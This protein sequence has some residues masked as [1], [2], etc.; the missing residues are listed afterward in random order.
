LTLSQGHTI[1]PFIIVF[2]KTKEWT[3]C[4]SQILVKLGGGILNA[5]EC[6]C[7]RGVRY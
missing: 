4:E 1:S 5:L 7:T 3:G 6:V 2:T